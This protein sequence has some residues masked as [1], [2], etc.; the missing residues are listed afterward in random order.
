MSGI[1]LIFVNKVAGLC[2]RAS[3]INK[4]A[5][6]RPGILLKKRLCHRCFPMNFAKFLRKLFYKTPS[7]DCFW[8]LS[9]IDLQKF[10]SIRTLIVDP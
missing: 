4:V 8:H 3:F 9:K 1:F 7:G 5:G 6:L 10:F 2:A